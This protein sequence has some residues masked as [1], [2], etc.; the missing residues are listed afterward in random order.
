MQVGLG[1]LGLAPSHFWEL[2]MPEFRMAITGHYDAHNAVQRQEWERT[3]WL[4]VRMLSPH[5]KKGSKLQPQ[6]LGV[7]PWERPEPG[8]IL[9]KDELRARIENRDGWL[10]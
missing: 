2:T 4:A 8:R 9:T 3:R 10:V 5:V 7:F 1:R 6:D